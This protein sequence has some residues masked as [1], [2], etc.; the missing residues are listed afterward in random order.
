MRSRWCAYWGC[1]PW[2]EVV[3]I[4]RLSPISDGRKVFVEM[5][6]NR[7]ITNRQF[8]V[9]SLNTLEEE[10]M[11]WW[12][13]EMV[14]HTSIFLWALFGFFWCCT[15][16]QCSVSGKFYAL[17]LFLFASALYFAAIY[18]SI[19]QRC[20]YLNDFVVP[21]LLRILLLVIVIRSFYQMEAKIS[22]CICADCKLAEREG[23]IISSES[24]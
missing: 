10:N 9:P 17:Y 15:R 5:L 2:H 18:S 11:S 23:K 16:L 24:S 3:W 13:V 20:K 21:N 14:I 8:A 4:L 12:S 19:W 6:L 22:F 7:S 1:L